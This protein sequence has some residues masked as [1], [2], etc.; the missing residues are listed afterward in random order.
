[1]TTSNGEPL[2]E[3]KSVPVLLYLILPDTAV[4]FSK[5]PPLRLKM[6][7][8]ELRALVPSLLRMKTIETELAVTEKLPTEISADAELA[9]MLNCPADFFSANVPVSNDASPEISILKPLSSIEPS[10]EK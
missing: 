5:S 1:M 4:M 8:D 10:T 3:L 9:I 2:A 6:P 7:P